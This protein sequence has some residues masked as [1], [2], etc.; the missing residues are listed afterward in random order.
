MQV[1]ET[2]EIHVVLEPLGPGRE[3]RTKVPTR[4]ELKSHQVR[5]SDRM[6]ISLSGT[7]LQIA[8]IT[9]GIQAIAPNGMTE[10]KWNIEPSRPGVQL[11]QLTTNII[12]KVEGADLPRTILTNSEEIRVDSSWAQRFGE[13]VAGNWQWLWAAIVIPVLTWLWNYGWGRRKRKEEL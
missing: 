13:F 11:L 8:E 2:W 1:G 3:D 4:G 12:A 6:E 7:G 5:L 10:W 9:P